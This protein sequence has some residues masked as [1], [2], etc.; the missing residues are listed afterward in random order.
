MRE[1]EARTGVHRETI[2][3]YLRYGLIPQPV[4]PR[5]NVADY[6]EEHVEAVIAVR[7]LQQ[8]SRYTLPQIQAMMSGASDRRTGANAFS[9]LETLVAARVGIDG[10]LVPIASLVSRYPEARRDARSLAAVGIVRIVLAED[11]PALSLT[12][13]ELV[14]IWGDMRALG[15]D[16]ALEFRPEMLDFY[17]EAAEFVAGWEARTFLDRTEGWIVEDAAAVM[18]Q[19]SLPLMLNFFG[20][21]RM[22][23]FMRNI[24]TDGRKRH[25]SASPD[26]LS[27]SPPGKARLTRGRTRG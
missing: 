2:R 18:V 12:D 9:H 19:H 1:L 8:D 16:E 15:F 10:H 23:A 21:L 22:K 3:V 24:A 11:G 26:A 7:R 20:L 4:R 25:A 5:R 13:A 27:T 14:S 17:V 6:G